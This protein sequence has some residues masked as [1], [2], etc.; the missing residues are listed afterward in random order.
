MEIANQTAAEVGASHQVTHLLQE[1][2]SGRKEA[3]NDLIP[4]VYDELCVIARS[5]LK[6][7]RRHHTFRTDVLVNEAYLRLCAQKDVDFENRN[8][9]FGIA[10]RIM[11]QILVDYAREYH[12]EKRGGQ[13]ER[14]YVE[15]IDGFS[16]ER[17]IDLVKLDQAL[18][19]LEEVDK[20]KCQIVEMRYFAGLTIDETARVLGTSP[21]SLKREW[22]MAKAWLLRALTDRRV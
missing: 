2:R 16:K 12:A 20:H 4:L 22:A 5:R 21:A 11:R 3:L 1:W 14:V 19:A 7:E 15:D 6:R 10:A 8:H 17:A 9:F 18:A 13:A